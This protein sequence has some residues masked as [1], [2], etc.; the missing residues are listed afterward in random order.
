ML[1]VFHSFRHIQMPT[2]IALCQV[3]EPYL[4]QLVLWFLEIVQKNIAVNSA[5]YKNGV[6]IFGLVIFAVEYV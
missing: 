6:L 5:F 3:T 4:A 1:W 2:R